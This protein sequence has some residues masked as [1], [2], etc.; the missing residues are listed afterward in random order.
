MI[1]IVSTPA[2]TW[3]CGVYWKYMWARIVAPWAIHWGNVQFWANPG[4]CTEMHNLAGIGT[5]GHSGCGESGMSG[6]STDNI[7]NLWSLL[8]IPNIRWI[9]RNS[10]LTAAR[11]RIWE[12]QRNLRKC[13]KS[14]NCN[15]MTKLRNPRE[16]D[17]SPIVYSWG[18]LKY[19]QKQESIGPRAQWL[20]GHSLEVIGWPSS[21]VCV[22]MNPMCA[23]S[24]HAHR[25]HVPWAG[26][27]PKDEA[28]A[29]TYTRA[30]LFINKVVTASCSWGATVSY[31]WL[32]RASSEL[33]YR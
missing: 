8:E 28:C 14:G 29:C 12:K 25:V 6:K 31:S 15:K 26:P 24:Q 13:T 10:A 5:E 22:C 32:V 33:S 23:S 2:S 9:S 21:C 20:L 19:W 1:P 3:I 27:H 17:N 16:I 4:K 30:H 11:T 18:H 7:W